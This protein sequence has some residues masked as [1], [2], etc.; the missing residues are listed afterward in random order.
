MAVPKP[1]EF[2]TA[3]CR[4][5]DD[6]TG[7]VVMLVT[8][9][10]IAKVECKAC[11]SAHKYRDVALPKSVQSRPGVRHV[12]AGQSR[13]AAVDLSPG[14]KGA[15]ARSPAASS[16]AVKTERGNRQRA[17]KIENAWQ[18]AMVR[19]S[20]EIPDE[21]SMALPLRNGQYVEHP[22]FGRGEV[23]SVTRPDK[24]DIL[25]KEGIKTLRCRL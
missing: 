7:H 13:E 19:H 22:V 16:P 12:R 8:G 5:C 2:I 24:A 10:V 3:K 18:E 20:A 21:Y 25:F 11:G 1:G 17:T 15:P 6:V 9:G 23:I 14:R 4:R